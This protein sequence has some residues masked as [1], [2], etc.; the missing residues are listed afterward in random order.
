MKGRKRL[1]ATLSAAAIGA[2]ALAAVP[3]S[4]AA[5]GASTENGGDIVSAASDFRPPL[6]TAAV[7]GKSVGGAAGFVK[8]GGEYFVYANVAAD[9]GNPASG[10]AAV[11]ADVSSVTTGASAVTLNAGSF[12]AGGVSYGYRGA[13]LTAN[14]ILT[15]GARAFTVTATDNAAN[16]NSLGGSVTVD[17]T[18]PKASDVQTTN[19]G[20]GTNGL[21][22][23]GD[24]LVLTVSEPVE[25][26]SILAGWN[27]TA[28]NVT[29]RI[30]DNSLL[31][32]GLGNDVV[33]VFNAANTATL[34]LGSVDLGRSDYVTGLVGGNVK[35]GASGT[36]STMTISG[37]TITV[38]LGTYEGEGLLGSNR[39]TAGGNGTAVWTPTATPYDRAAN[40]M[41]TAAASESGPADKE[42]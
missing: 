18:A 41:S 34:P 9:T 22:E 21:A 23:Q 24:T 35:F 26:E 37:N 10:I 11:R 19:V 1:T 38:V 8:Q 7:V 39:I 15:E 17:N 42:F 5:F 12:S 31:G 20:G 14:A 4:L 13:A 16:A 33:Q 40:A 30:V 29:V 32:L 28:T 2:V 27:G 36:K 6:V 25:P 3:V